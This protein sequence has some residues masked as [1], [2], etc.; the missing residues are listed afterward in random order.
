MTRAETLAAALG[1][2]MDFSIADHSFSPLYSDTGL[3]FDGTPGIA[4]L[5]FHYNRGT[6]SFGEPFLPLLG[7]ETIAS[8]ERSVLG[9]RQQLG[10]GGTL[11]VA[12]FDRNSFLVV[13]K[14]IEGLS[15]R[16][17]RS[18]GLTEARASVS[19]DVHLFEGYLPACDK[20]EPDETFPIIMG[21]RVLEGRASGDGMNDPITVVPSD[22]GAVRV[23]FS[24][25]AL[26]IDRERIGEILAFAPSS[27]ETARARTLDWLETT[28]GELDVTADDPAEARALAESAYTLAYNACRAP[29]RLAGP[30]SIFP[31]RGSYAMLAPWDSGFHNLALEY[32]EPGIAEDS[33]FLLTDTMRADGKIACFVASTW[34]RPQLSQPALI[35]WAAE[36]LLRL[37]G[38]VEFAR[39]ILPK[40]WLNSEWWLTQRMTRF[41]V[42]G[43]PHGIRGRLGQ[44]PALGQGPHRRV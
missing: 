4:K 41:G 33:L 7:D 25:N 2:T 42:I 36:R 31:A 17:V 5:F 26:E 20:R 8:E 16:F 22:S 34:D 21:M 6:T 43:C 28:I 10:S 3:G 38:D 30:V 35:G 37:R 1:T 23:V 19:G 15:F 12:F 14:G 39:N 32:M 27:I 24:V 40:M 29:G 11:A 13:G 9:V 18:E 44:L